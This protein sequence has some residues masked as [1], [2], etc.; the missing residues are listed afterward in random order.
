MSKPLTAT[1]TDGNELTLVKIDFTIADQPGV[2]GKFSTWCDNRQSM[3]QF[4]IHKLFV[5]HF[6]NREGVHV[7]GVGEER[8]RS[9]VMRSQ[10]LFAR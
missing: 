3:M 2:L 6:M 4:I 1:H 9:F 10:P 7:P 8:M 5:P